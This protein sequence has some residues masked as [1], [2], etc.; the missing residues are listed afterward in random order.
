M[1]FQFLTENFLKSF[2]GA[3][4]LVSHDKMF[5]DNVTNRTVEISLG[6][7]YDFN[8]PYTQYLVLREE[9]REMQLAAQKNQAKKIEETEK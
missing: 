2:S 8:K 9:M 1:P 6:K 5:L 3:V 4:V 7:I